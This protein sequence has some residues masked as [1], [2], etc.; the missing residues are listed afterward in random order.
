MVKRRI[1][2]VLVPHSKTMYFVE[3]GQPRGI[4]Y[5]AFKAFEDELNKKRGNLKV[6]VVFF[7]TTREKM[8]PNLLA[9]LGDI[10]AAGFTITS[11]RD[12]VVDFAIPSTTKPVNE[13]V[14]T[15]PQS[16]Q[17]A[18]VDDLAGKEV[19]VRKSSSYW[20]HLEQLNARF[21]KEGK[22]AIVLRPAPEDLEDEDLLEMLNAGLFGIAVVDDYKLDIW[23]KIF[24]EDQGASGSAGQHG[25]RAGVGDPAEQP[26]AQ[27][28]ARRVPQD[29]SPGHD[30]R[31][32]AAQAVH[33][34]HE[35]R[36]ER[37]LAGRAQEVSDRGRPVSEVRRQVRRR[38]PAHDGAGLPGVAPRSEGEEPGRRGRRDA[39][40]AGDGQGT[41]RLATSASSSPTST[42]A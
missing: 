38:L 3:R 33:R 14:V 17:L 4:V 20:E 5:E 16:P 18:S 8:V 42:P 13:I 25:R 19:F 15:G 9:G 34:Q 22:A 7:P 41:G 6:N 28:R 1:I 11:E 27:G 30:V 12:K 29:A 37:A 24:P 31:Q 2:R 39:G 21:K 26:A 36:R 40:D 32:H 35:V 10:I 23:T